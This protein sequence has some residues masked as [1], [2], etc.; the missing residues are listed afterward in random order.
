MSMYWNTRLWLPGLLLASALGACTGPWGGPGGG[1]SDELRFA[2]VQCVPDVLRGMSLVAGQSLSCVFRLEGSSGRSASLRCEHDS[3]AAADCGAAAGMQL[4]PFGTH[5]LPIQ[6]GLFILSTSGLGPGRRVVV[7]RADDGEHLA[8]YRLEVEI[9]A[10]NGVNEQ[11]GIEFNCGGRTDG[12]ARIAAGGEVS[13]QVRFV[14]P[15]PDALS[16][17][18]AVASGP[19]PQNEATPFGGSGQAPHEVRWRWRTSASEAGKTWTYAFTVSDG[20]APAV[21]RQLVVTVE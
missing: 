6:D 4:Q 15:D 11:P 7:W 2:E 20:T 1:G 5:P 21:T 3:G 18:Y 13:C 9:V 14:D 17:S 8:R 16:W 19:A 10:D 12:T